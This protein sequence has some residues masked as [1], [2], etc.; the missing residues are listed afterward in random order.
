MAWP[1][2]LTSMRSTCRP[3]APETT[4]DRVVVQKADYR[5]TVQGNQ[6]M[7]AAWDEQT[8]VK[9]LPGGLR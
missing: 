5:L 4:G 2:E 8:L 1:S 6:R 3:P 9:V 7:Q